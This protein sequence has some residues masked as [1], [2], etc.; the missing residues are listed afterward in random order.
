MGFS[1]VFVVTNA[2]RLKTWQPT[3]AK[4][5]TDMVEKKLKVEGMMCEHCAGRVREAVEGVGGVRNVVVNLDEGMVT[6]EAGMLA[7]DE[8]LVAAVEAAG[9][10]ASIA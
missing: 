5:N 9:Y 1:S 8:K 7:S 2:L 4:G 10:K 3:K 6:L